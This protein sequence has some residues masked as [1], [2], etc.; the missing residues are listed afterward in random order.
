M[1]KR[2]LALAGVAAI[3]ALAGCGSDSGSS[4]PPT[5]TDAQKTAIATRT[6][7]AIRGVQAVTRA[8]L[9]GLGGAN[10]TRSAHRQ[11]GG[12]TP[13]VVDG[14]TYFASVTQNSQTMA[15]EHIFSDQAGTNLVETLTLTEST[16]ANSDQQIAFNFSGSLLNGTLTATGTQG[17]ST[18]PGVLKTLAMNISD[19]AGDSVSTNLTASQSGNTQTFTGPF[20]VSS[21]NQTINGTL[22]INLNAQTGDLLNETL[23]VGNLDAEGDSASFTINA[24]GSE[25]IVVRDSGG[26]TLATAN[27]N[28]AGVGTITYADGTQVPINI[29][30]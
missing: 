24:D 7:T 5:I 26:N 10:T 11:S 21:N 27:V 6:E 18:T 23:T 3:L 12:L 14:V 13:I 29:N 17:T 25:V 8:G 22:T 30:G 1:L 15:T 4:S 19:T 2:A 9:F 28:S 16:L 20:N